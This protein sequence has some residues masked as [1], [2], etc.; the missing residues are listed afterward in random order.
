FIS[1]PGLTSPLFIERNHEVR[2]T[3]LS[4]GLSGQFFENAWFHPFVNSNS[5]GNVSTSRPYRRQC[6]RAGQA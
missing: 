5:S 3:T 6:R 4:A 1:A 2:F